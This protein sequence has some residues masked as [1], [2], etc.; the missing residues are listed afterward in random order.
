MFSGFEPFDEAAGQAQRQIESGLINLISTEQLGRFHAALSEVPHPAGSEGDWQVIRTLES[1]F[2]E[3]GLDVN[4]HEIDVYLSR[5]LDAELELISPIRQTLSIQE[6]Q[7]RGDTY[8]G[9]PALGP[10]WNAYSGS[11]DVTA[12]VVYA[13]YGTRDDFEQLKTMGIDCTGRIVIA[14]YGGN[15]RGYKAKFAEEAGAVGLIIYTDPGDAVHGLTYPD[16]GWASPGSIQRGSIKTL[17]YAGDPL[18]PGVSVNSNGPKL[19]PEGLALPKIPVQPIGWG[20][21]E[22]ILRHMSESEGQRV[23][24]SWQGGLLFNYAVTGGSDVRVRLRVQQERATMKTANVI[25]K[26]EGSVMPRSAVIIGCHHDAWTF[27]AGD[28]NAGLMIVMELARVFSEL[29]SAGIKPA[30]TLIFA[31]WGAEEFGIIGSTEWVEENLPDLEVGV[32]TYI[33]LDMAAM[34]PNF[35]A[36]AAPSMKKLVMDVTKSIPNAAG[37]GNSVYD[38]WAQRAGGDEPSVGRLGGG[39]DHVPFYCH[40]GVPCVAMGASGA[41]GISYHSNY[42]TLDW[43]HL[44]VGDDYKPAQ[45][46]GR[47]AGVVASRFANAQI[48]PIDPYGYAVDM[49]RHLDGLEDRAEELGVEADFGLLRHEIRKLDDSARNA[50][51]ILRRVRTSGRPLSLKTINIVNSALGQLERELLLEDGLPERPWYRNAYVSPDPTSGYSAWMLPLLRHYI[52][53]GDEEGLEEATL[54]LADCVN[55]MGGVL[56]EVRERLSDSPTDPKAGLNQEMGR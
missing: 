40:A 34:G 22:T 15:F 23:P 27:G 39:S 43:Y 6:P 7:V 51:A 42:D 37:D 13:N 2:T 32:N 14:R 8:S 49:N 53:A 31:A 16:G 45:M 20:A 12:E 26:I 29:R 48:V 21:A 52:E 47:V 38:A 17:P 18:T 35:W 50:E 46:V 36:S 24:E 30:R 4:V 19:D 3:M 54:T 33:N 11:G 5:L 41:R 1:E 9:N 55:R 28:P 44:V 25:A 10:G 56:N